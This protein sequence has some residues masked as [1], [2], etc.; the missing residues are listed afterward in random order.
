MIN[1]NGKIL[2]KVSELQKEEM[3]FKGI[4]WIAD[5]EYLENNEPYLFKIVTD[6]SGTF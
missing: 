2:V 6:R 4:F 3:L 5:R 1:K